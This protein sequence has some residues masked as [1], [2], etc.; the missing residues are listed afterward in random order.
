MLDY[1]QVRLKGLAR[2][3]LCVIC[4]RRPTSVAAKETNLLELQRQ[5]E[6][7]C[8]QKVWLLYLLLL[9][10]VASEVVEGFAVL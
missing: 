5:G 6:G 4:R 7:R 9:H 2:F 10:V 3:V 8:F 1:L